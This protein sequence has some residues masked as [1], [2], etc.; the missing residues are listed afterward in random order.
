MIFLV[1][2]TSPHSIHAAS[3]NCSHLPSPCEGTDGSDAI[4]AS[5]IND[6]EFTYEILGLGADTILVKNIDTTANAIIRAG[7]GNDKLQA[8]HLG[9]FSV[10]VMKEMILYQ[11]L[12]LHLEI[13]LAQGVQ[14]L[15]K[16]LQNLHPT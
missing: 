10:W 8:L 2:I 5:G 7:P 12:L 3:I 4:T 13:Y 14:A 6:V 16:L 1:L 15:I 9:I 11:Y